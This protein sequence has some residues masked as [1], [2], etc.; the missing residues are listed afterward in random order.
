MALQRI[1]D[2]LDNWL[3]QERARARSLF[4]LSNG[5]LYLAP[6][7]AGCALRADG[8]QAERRRGR[9]HLV[10]MAA[11]LMVFDSFSFGADGARMAELYFC[12]HDYMQQVP[13][14]M[15]MCALLARFP[16]RPPKGSMSTLDADGGGVE[17]G[18]PM[19]TQCPT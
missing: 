4:A 3:P 13:H 10:G 2:A 16:V 8:K 15:R 17:I 7:A 1:G 6:A 5:G 12:L 19:R 11:S 14:A 9:A 18:A